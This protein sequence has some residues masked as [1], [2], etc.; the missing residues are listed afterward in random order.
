MA[1]NFEKNYHFHYD[2]KGSTLEAQ[3]EQE[4]WSIVN[5]GQVASENTLDKVRLTIEYAADL[6]VQKFG[7]GFPLSAGP[8][9]RDEHFD[10]ASSQYNLNNLY[11]CG[12]SVLA[13]S[14]LRNEKISG[15]TTPWVYMGMLFSSF[16]WHVEDLWLNSLN[17][18][19]CG[20]TKT[21]YVVPEADKE[22][23]DQYVIR[24]TGR[25]QFLNSITYMLDPLELIENGIRV[26]KTYQRP[27]EFVLTLFNAYHAGFSQGFNVG[28]AVNVVTP[29]S[30]PVIK[31]FLTLSAAT[32]G[33]KAP[34]ISYEWLLANNV[35]NPHIL[36]DKVQT[37][38]QRLVSCEQQKVK[39]ALGK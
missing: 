11:K 28:E 38:Y 31:K 29:D 12:G 30:L 18:N 7:S 6:P 25:R 19:H 35:S 34:V 33:Q 8:K 23:F 15:V 4:Y 5:G 9:D 27:R 13:M 10:Y 22:K 36:S 3:H 14:D 32:K 16:C 17:Y 37:E 21:W 2:R 20:S 1:H 26:Y 39:K 24:K